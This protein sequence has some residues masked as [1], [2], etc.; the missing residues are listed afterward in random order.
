MDGW[1]DG[2]TGEEG[3]RGGESRGNLKRG[4]KLGG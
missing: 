4:K 3:M 1:M 2:R